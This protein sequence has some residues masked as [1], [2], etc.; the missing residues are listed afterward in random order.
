VW[1]KP[2]PSHFTP[3]KRPDTHWNMVRWLITNVIVT[4]SCMKYYA[5]VTIK[6]AYSHESVGFVWSFMPRYPS[7]RFFFRLNF[8]MHVSFPLM[9]I[10]KSH[11][12]HFS[13]INHIHNICL[14]VLTIKLEVLRCIVF[15]SLPTFTVS[16][17][18]CYLTRGGWIKPSRDG[19][20]KAPTKY[21]FDRPAQQ[22]CQRSC[23][24][25]TA[26]CIAPK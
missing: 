5:D 26:N 24:P 4:T 13:Q 3:G 17:F 10:K 9:C 25:D 21:C 7:V 2:R 18:L 23:R 1:S 15:C 8:C 11:P 6:K 16:L 12:F 22:S 19:N 20:Q 14:W